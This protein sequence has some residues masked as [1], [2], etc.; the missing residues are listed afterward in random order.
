MPS[1]AEELAA[2]K[3]LNLA[4]THGSKLQT[5]EGLSTPEQEDAKVSKTNKGNRK[6]TY[7]REAKLKLNAGVNS[8]DQDLEFR[9][10][11]NAQ[12]KEDQK[13][14]LEASRNLQNF[15]E[16]KVKKAPTTP[17]RPS[18]IHVA[19]EGGNKGVDI[20]SKES[21]VQVIQTT[22][23]KSVESVTPMED[24]GV[25]EVEERFPNVEPKSQDECASLSQSAQRI[26]NRAEKKAKKQ[27]EKI[28]MK[29]VPGIVRVTLKL[30][31]NQGLYTIYQPDVFEKNGSYIVFGEAQ[32]GG[33]IMQ[34]QRQ[35]QLAAQMLE[36]PKAVEEE[37]P[38]IPEFEGKENV[39][40]SGL[41]NKDIEL[42]VGQ[43]GCTR[44]KAVAALRAN[45]GDLVNAIMSLT[46]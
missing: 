24:D 19:E 17:S 41:D 43:A 25:P 11:Q 33:G 29:R 12:K 23:N 18:S 15:N 36:T 20:N 45:K 6:P 14:K 39:D 3:K 44:S 28:G 5:A 46:T 31:G 2:L 10:K 1:V 37:V 7:E 9:S 16:A 22:E 38:T 21:S 13:K 30:G 27:M 40:E 42:V 26:P 34:Q 35:A 8:V 32:Q 4:K